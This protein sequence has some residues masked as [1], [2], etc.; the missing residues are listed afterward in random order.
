[1]SAGRRWFVGPGRW[2]GDAADIYRVMQTA[3][4]VEVGRTL[5][6]LR[7]QPIAGDTTSTALGL[8]T[9]LFGNRR[10][11]GIA[12]AQRSLAL[13]DPRG[14]GV[15]RLHRV[16]LRPAD[17]RLRKIGPVGV[18]RYPRH[19][20]QPAPKTFSQRFISQGRI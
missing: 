5:H 17:F 6:D 15:R 12:M 13:G 4:P 20:T 1:M 8:M 9:E 16:H 11:E 2:S 14:T 19:R 7:G 3:R 18:T 10:G